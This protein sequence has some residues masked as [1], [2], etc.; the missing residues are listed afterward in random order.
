MRTNDEFQFGRRHKVA[1]KKQL[2]ISGESSKGK[3]YLPH[4]GHHSRANSAGGDPGDKADMFNIYATS[5]A[6]A[7]LC[8]ETL[9][10][11]KP[12]QILPMI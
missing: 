12:Q 4:R 2:V 8:G 11:R 1:E 5:S 3:I 9:L 6:N 7:L 10:R